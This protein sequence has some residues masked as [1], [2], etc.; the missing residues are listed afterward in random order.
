[1]KKAINFLS[2]I[3]VIFLL[4]GCISDV[5]KD[6]GDILKNLGTSPDDKKASKMSMMLY[7]DENANLNEMNEPSP[8]MVV[9]V[10]MT[11]D[12]KL[13]TSS[14][15]SLTGDIKSALGNSYLKHEEYLVTPDSFTNV[16]EFSLEKGTKYIGIIASYRSIDNAV[17][18][19]SIKVSDQDENYAV[20]VALSE[21]GLDV[22]VQ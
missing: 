12:L 7:A 22:E 3:V 10:Q 13:V 11:S 4:S 8:I 6:T 1:M 19:G 20:H 5:L 2:F 18:R 9:I 16:E 21:N 14:Y 17:W 15:E